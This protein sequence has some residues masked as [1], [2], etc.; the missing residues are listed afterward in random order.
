MAEVADTPQPLSGPEAARLIDF[1]RACKAAARAVLLY[2]AGH[3]AI[4]VTLGRIVHLTSSTSLAEPLNISV[5]PDTLLLDER[6]T[7]RGDA[8]IGELATLLHSH[9]IGLMRVMPGA[10]V[11]AWR[12]FLLLLGRAPD[13]V[14][15]EGGIARVW[16]MM[17]GRHVE[18]REI[19]YT[20]V[21]R[22]REAGLS[23]AWDRVV[24]NCLQGSAFDLDEDTIRELIGVAGDPERLAQLMSTADRTADAGG[25]LGARTAA[26][27]RMMRS[28]I[29]AISKK[30]PQRLE[31]V[32]RNMAAAVGQLSADVL[33]GLL[34]QHDDDEA[35]KLV[36]AI[37]SRM[38][39]G[40]IAKFVARQV[41]ADGTA[42]DRLAQAFHTLV[43]ESEQKDRMLAL[44]RADVAASPLGST[45]GFAGVWNK[46]AE[47]LLTSYS[48]QS[49]VSE[50]Y[51]R[52]L[53]GARTR[54]IEVEQTS[55]DPPERITAWLS[56]I[57]TSALRA[58]DLTL[59]LDLL[60]IETDDGKWGELMTPVVA[61]LDDLLL[62][63]DFDSAL[64]LIDVLAREAAGTGSKLRR[65]H[66]IT[67]I[68][69]LVA[70]SMMRHLTTH[71]ATVDEAQFQRIRNMCVSL[72][73]V[74]VRPLAEALSVEERPVSR[75]RLT[76]ILTSFGAVA[77]KTI[78]RLKASQN[79]AV[80]RTAISLMRQ[81]GGS[82]ALPDLKELLDDNE[83]QVQREAVRAIVNV[84][85][86]AA[87]RILEQALTSGTDRSREAI[88]QSI[89]VVR[90]ERAAPLFAYILGHVDHRGALANVF[91][92][93]IESLGALRD[94]VG[95]P[96]LKAALSK[97]EWWAPRRTSAMRTAAAS[98]LA[99][100]G[101]PEAVAVLEEAVASGPRGVRAAARTALASARARRPAPARGDA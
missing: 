26:V 31:G 14:R 36:Q 75:E 63:G 35:P 101:T 44:A 9:L 91:T 19:D 49:Y 28:V 60:R 76:A 34:D 90:D 37:V 86:D 45:D 50:A 10:D 82:E 52:E 39:D 89:S 54:A 20:E 85:T 40:T 92:R 87:Y 65:Q 100:I 11:E 77:R 47:K 15:A 4:S 83:P 95:I 24:A 27:L 99:R 72:G 43:P 1:A 93:A 25:G 67:A 22:E 94:P 21:L 61:L 48:D 69:L 12:S 58:L 51:A 81:F 29:D 96:A 56:S 71:L 2:P 16:A 57:A 80:R 33:M 68:D 3:P 64:A 8:A 41:I 42:T 66:A 70:G 5:M 17:A 55:D 13:A 53:S 38:S 6:P 78:E 46:V 73:V 88:M 79:A 74:L 59:L 97:G 7:P 23:A 30:E 18:L 62:V 98:A 32:L 84:G